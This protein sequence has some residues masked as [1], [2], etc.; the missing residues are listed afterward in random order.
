MFDFA[1]LAKRRADEA[2]RITAV[3]L[4]FEMKGKRV[5]F[6]GYQ[7]ST[8]IN[9]NQSHIVYCMATNEI[10]NGCG[11]STEAVLPLN[12]KRRRDKSVENCA[13]SD[14]LLSLILLWKPLARV[15][16]LEQI[17]PKKT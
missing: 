2:D 3:A 11:L 9:N 16:F 15:F 8:S 6:D 14:L 10:T 17:K 13:L 1:V 12:W 4:N 7:I 5:A